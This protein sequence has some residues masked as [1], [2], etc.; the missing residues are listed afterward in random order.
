MC[1]LEEARNN[2]AYIMAK[3]R[4]YSLLARWINERLEYLDKNVVRKLRKRFV[5]LEEKIKQILEEQSLTGG[6]SSLGPR[7]LS[8]PEE[9]LI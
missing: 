2:L 4:G 7:K 6:N 5:A 3:L 1:M 8:V 9:I